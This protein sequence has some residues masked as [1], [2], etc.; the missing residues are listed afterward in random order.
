MQKQATNDIRERYGFSEEWLTACKEW[1]EDSNLA[2]SER[3]LWK[4]IN[5]QWL[6]T[7]IRNNGVQEKHQIKPSW[8]QARKIVIKD[9]FCLMV[10]YGIDISQSGYSQL[11]TKLKIEVGNSSVSAE[12]TSRQPSWEPKANRC[13]KLA[14]TDG[15]ETIYG[16]EHEPIPSLKEIH[17]GMKIEF[18][19]PIECRKQTLKLKSKHL[20]VLGGKVDELE[21]EF[22]DFKILGEKVGVDHSQFGSVSLPNPVQSPEDAFKDDF[23]D[24]FFNNVEMPGEEE[25]D[26]FFR[27]VELPH[28]IDN[29]KKAKIDIQTFVINNPKPFVYLK[30]LKSPK[31]W[32]EE[33]YVIKGYVSSLATNLRAIKLKDKTTVWDLAVNIG[34]GTDTRKFNISKDLLISWMGITP[35]ERAKT[36]KAVL[37]SLLD[38]VARRLENFNGLV[39]MK[40]EQKKIVIIQMTP[41][42]RGHLQQLK[43]RRRLVGK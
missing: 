8:L 9:T 20:T 4:N 7:D 10:L 14:L 37:K 35:A 3:D 24:D 26:D 1:C 33:Y 22:S 19:G 43:I 23:D 15:F 38:G 21:V 34:D 32:I 30:Y 28:E 25:D 16:V 18:Q 6:S 40:I 5:E 41:F 2:Q 12:N 31:D 36:S 27:N 11:Q 29:P 17:P 13:L 42:N 39:K